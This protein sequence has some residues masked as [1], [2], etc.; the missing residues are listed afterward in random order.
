MSRRKRGSVAE[1]SNAPALKAGGR[2]RSAR[3]N[4]AASGFGWNY[5]IIRKTRRIPGSQRTDGKSIL[6]RLYDIHEVY[7]GKNGKPRSWTRGP[8]S[9]SGHESAKDL[10]VALA[11]MLADTLKHPILEIVGNKLFKR[12]HDR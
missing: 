7:Y 6:I 10:R 11:M 9:P 8:I 1:R 4:R 12:N 3:S 5:R 2:K